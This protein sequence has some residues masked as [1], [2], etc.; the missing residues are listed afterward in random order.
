MFVMM[1]FDVVLLDVINI[2]MCIECIGDEYVI[3]GCKWFIINVVYLNC[4]IF[5][6]MGKIDFDVEL[7]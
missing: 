1:E 5:I 4:K 3:N 7:Y 6:V 2:M